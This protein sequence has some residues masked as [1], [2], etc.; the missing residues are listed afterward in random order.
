M[1]G[2]EHQV[3]GV[4]AQFCLRFPYDIAVQVGKQQVSDVLGR[5]VVG[6]GE[7]YGL[8]A[9]DLFSQLFV[10]KAGLPA[11]AYPEPD[12]PDGC[13]GVVQYVGW[14][15]GYATPAVGVGGSDALTLAKQ[16]VIVPCWEQ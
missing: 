14:P 5:A 12:R 7:Q 16:A 15:S 8:A 13:D 3:N 9:P 10:S 1:V 4:P 6:G 2:N 11:V